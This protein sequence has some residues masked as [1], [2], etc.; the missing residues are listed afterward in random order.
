MRARR[1]ALS[2]PGSSE[3]MLAKA[4]GLAADEI[5]VDLED[6]VAPAAKDEA[7]GLVARLLGE[8][9]GAAGAVAVR[10]NA[11]DTGW[12]HRDVLAL[13]EGA[14]PEIDSLV[15]PKVEDAEEVR[16]L[17]R[18]LGMLG[19]RASAIRVQALVETA[20]GLQRAG[21]IAAASPRIDA[22][23]L[24]YADLAASLGRASRDDPPERWL[25][26]QETVL[27]AARA[28]GVQAIDGPFLAIRDEEGLRRRAEHAR[29]L[30]Y[31]GK[32]AV[33]PD[34]VPVLNEVFTPSADEIERARTIVSA[35]EA[36]G[37]G[38]LEIDGRMVDEA[39]RK[40][41][42]QVLARGDAA[43]SVR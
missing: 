43:R 39:S 31:D 35:L 32:W 36:E 23:I 13:V 1:S 28:A 5:V 17:D 6:A 3:R 38:A 37:P 2:V 24:G 10:V 34:Q 8:G 26:A 27:V 7:R 16:W 20:D 4:A 14:G 15:L 41:A 11:L 19:E 9:L 40:L 33:H 12:C 25:H 22:L 42:L 18:F 30:G 21:E 29:A